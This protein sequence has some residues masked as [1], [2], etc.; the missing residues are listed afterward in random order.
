MTSHI[1]LSFYHLIRLEDYPVIGALNAICKQIQKADTKE[2]HGS[3]E[4][5][6]S[7]HRE[8]LAGFSLSRKQVFESAVWVPVTATIDRNFCMATID[9]PELNTELYLYNFRK[10]PAY[11]IVVMLSCISVGAAFSRMRPKQTELR[12]KYLQNHSTFY[13]TQWLPAFGTQP[14]IHIELSIHESIKPLTSD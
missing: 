3:H 10:L 4:V 14:A 13:E 9:I 7:E 2:E 5:K 11:R 12:E 8:M 1:R 6:L